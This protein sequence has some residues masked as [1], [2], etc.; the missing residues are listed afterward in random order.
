MILRLITNERYVELPESVPVNQKAEGGSQ[1]PEGRRQKVFLSPVVITI[2]RRKN[3]L[4]KSFNEK[5]SLV[6]AEYSA[7][8]VPPSAFRLL[9][10]AFR[11]LAI[12]FCLSLTAP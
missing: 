11:L 1:K 6:N 2:A 10:S 7:F 9:P 3:F 4:C 8:R 12:A 5:S